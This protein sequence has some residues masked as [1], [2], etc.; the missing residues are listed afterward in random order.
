MV[1]G[2]R[3]E[4]DLGD[5][6]EHLEIDR[7]LSELHHLLDAPNPR[8]S[9][10]EFNRLNFCHIWNPALLGRHVNRAASLARVVRGCT[11]CNRAKSTLEYMCITLWIADQRLK[12]EV[13]IIIIF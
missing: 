9:A 2:G 6:I 10:E 3:E 4:V 1:E 12:P 13:Y 11:T 5:G 7:V 8:L